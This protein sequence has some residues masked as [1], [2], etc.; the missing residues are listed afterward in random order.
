MRQLGRTAVCLCTA[1]AL[2]AIAAS[3]AL[4]QP[5]EIGRCA[6]VAV[7]KTGKYTTVTCTALAKP[8]A[9][10]YEWTPGTAEGK[11]HFTGTSTK[12]TLETIHKVKVT[13]TGEKAAGEYTGTKTVGNVN[14]TFTG[15][16]SLAKKCQTEGS[17][18]GEIK[19]NPLAGQLEWENK[20][21]KKVAVDLF[22]QEGEYFVTFRCG[23]AESKVRGS[24]LVNVIAGKM[25]T[26]FVEKF[27]AKEGVQ[28]PSEYETAEGTKVPDF[29]EA[30]LGATEFVRAG[31]TV[32]NT[33]K[34]EEALEVNWFV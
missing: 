27:T 30:D 31:Q 14:V 29:L 28:K 12:A 24:V 4:A 13:C 34:N 3:A 5:P 17:A 23:P 33:Q 11:N 21:L 19:V 18:E 26:S 20:A 9:G 7:A 22:P 6:K 10:E 8:G 2:S 25:E 32:A 1:L 16:V 15:C